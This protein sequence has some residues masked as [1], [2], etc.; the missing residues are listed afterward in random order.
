LVIG[1]LS[2]F[3]DDSIQFYWDIISKG[4]LCDGARIEFRRVPARL[5]CSE[6]R[7]EYTL[8]GELTPCP[9]CGS[10]RVRITAGDEFRLDSIDVETNDPESEEIDTRD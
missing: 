6:C 3:V 5:L 4:T 7:T 1:G 8:E 10:P 2:S 9:S